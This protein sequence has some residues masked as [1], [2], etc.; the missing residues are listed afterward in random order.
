MIIVCC[1]CEYVG[2]V[3]FDSSVCDGSS[4]WLDTGFLRRPRSGLWASMASGLIFATRHRSQLWTSRRGNPC[5]V[6]PTNN[7]IV[8]GEGLSTIENGPRNFWPKLSG[9]S[10]LTY[11]CVAVDVDEGIYVGGEVLW[12]DIGI[13][14]CAA[15]V[16]S[17]FSNSW[18][19]TGSWSGKIIPGMTGDDPIVR[20]DE[21]VPRSG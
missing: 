12:F 5:L 10:I 19:S 4:S 3:C 15:F 2:L 6:Y 17:V 14:G 8:E 20:K 7:V 11:A 9:F 21:E 1:S 13:G 18:L 16:C